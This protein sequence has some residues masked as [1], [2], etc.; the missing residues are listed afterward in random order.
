MSSWSWDGHEGEPV[1]VEVY[2][3]ADEV[4]LFVNG[5]SVGRQPAGGSTATGRCSRPCTSRVCSRPSPGA[6]APRVAACESARLPGPVLLE[7]VG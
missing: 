1:A 7:A 2:A 5:A 3:D 6:A 4:E